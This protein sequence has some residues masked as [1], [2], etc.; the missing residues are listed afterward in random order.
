MNNKVIG[1]TVQ[2]APRLLDQVRAKVRALHYSRKTEE[3]Y[4]NWI[5]RYILFHG[6]R[7]PREMGAPELESFLPSPATVRNVAASTQN[8]AEA[9]NADWRADFDSV[10]ID[11]MLRFRA[12]PLRDK[13]QAMEDMAELV[14]HV[15][16]V[17][18]RAGLPVIDP[19]TGKV[20]K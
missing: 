20:L 12:L 4:V 16:A 13:I 5:K 2:N 19:K 17:R 7:H 14:K 8:Q 11:Q 10:R 18:R 9:G 3:S 1:Q 15:H 6:K